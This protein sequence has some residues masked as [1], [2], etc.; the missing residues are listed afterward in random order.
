VSG[1]LQGLMDLFQG[2]DA[3]PTTQGVAAFNA[4][5]KHLTRLFEQWDVIQKKDLKKLND[6]L[7]TAGLP[8]VDVD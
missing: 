8:T 6:Q 4:T 2:A 3:V 7:Q 5:E 1:E